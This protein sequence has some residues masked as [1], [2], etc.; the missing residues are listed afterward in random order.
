M[1]VIAKRVPGTHHEH[2]HPRGVRH[3]QHLEDE[4]TANLVGGVGDEGVAGGYLGHFDDVSEDDLELLGQ[5]RALY[6]FGD[7]GAHAGVEFDWTGQLL[8]NGRG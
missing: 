5:G 4:G 8:L 6:T 7:F 1:V 2:C 3:G